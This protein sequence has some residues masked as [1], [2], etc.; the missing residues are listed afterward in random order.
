MAAVT[1]RAASIRLVT[2]NVA[3]AIVGLVSWSTDAPATIDVTTA[4]NDG[5][6]KQAIGLKSGTITAE[7]IIDADDTNL[8]TALSNGF[9]GVTTDCYFRIND[10][11]T[12]DPTATPVTAD[13]AWSAYVVGTLTTS[14]PGDAARRTIT[15]YRQDDL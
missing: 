12:I 10:P 14:G 4:G 9:E 2:D 6:T 5:F 3:N 1:G 11:E 13:Y 7:V 15:F 8:V